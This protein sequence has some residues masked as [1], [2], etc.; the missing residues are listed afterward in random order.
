MWAAS[1]GAPRSMSRS[2]DAVSGKAGAVSIAR[3]HAANFGRGGKPSRATIA[4]HSAKSTVAEIGSPAAT[5]PTTPPNTADL[6][7]FFE[8]AHRSAR[9]TGSAVPRATPRLA[10]R[11]TAQA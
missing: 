8:T 4:A 6:E 2:I 9:A 5:V 1:T 10:L 11:L 3:V 7:R